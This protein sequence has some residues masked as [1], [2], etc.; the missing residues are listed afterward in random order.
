MAIHINILS[1]SINNIDYCRRE[2]E[3]LTQKD[4]LPLRC[5]PAEA[6]VV[7]VTLKMVYTL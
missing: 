1:R 3:A 5:M 2:F 7:F 6:L 4:V